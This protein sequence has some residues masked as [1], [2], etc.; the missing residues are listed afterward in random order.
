[1]I[2]KNI[3]KYLAASL[4]FCGFAAAFTSCSSDEDPFFT[5]GEEDAPRILNT[6]H[7]CSMVSRSL[8]E[9]R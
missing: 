7:G 8:K 2:T 1:M 6:S 5:A 4:V 3:L 9:P